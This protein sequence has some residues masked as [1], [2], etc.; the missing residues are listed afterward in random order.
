MSR[1]CRFAV[2]LGVVTATCAASSAGH[3]QDHEQSWIQ[4][5]FTA[6]PSQHELATAPTP[7][8]RTLVAITMAAPEAIAHAE[9]GGDSCIPPPLRRALADVGTMF[10]S[11][12]ITSTCRSQSRNAAAG[13]A[14]RSLHLS[15]QAVDFRVNG[16]PA[17]VYAFL[18]KHP[19]VGGLKHYGGGLFH[20]DTGVRRSF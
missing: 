12:S 9:S 7:R 18:A 10:G 1:R 8:R 14:S 5:A 15:G 16:Q 13:G 4:S 2:A 3:A 19:D 20:I 17:A 6:R 11:M